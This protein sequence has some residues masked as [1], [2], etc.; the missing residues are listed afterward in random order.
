MYGIYV[1]TFIVYSDE[2]YNVL[3]YNI[4]T[5]SVFTRQE[6]GLCYMIHGTDLPSGAKIEQHLWFSHTQC[7]DWQLGI[8]WSETGYLHI[9]AKLPTA[10]ALNTLRSRYNGIW[11]H[12]HASSL[13]HFNEIWLDI[14]ANRSIKKKPTLMAWCQ[15]T[16]QYLTQCMMSSWNENIFNVTGPL[17]G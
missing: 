12:F 8:D 17:C 16:K 9:V 14:I 11:M 15:M 10:L 7:Y 5:I 2:P 3:Q 6:Y 13:L 1:Y 4:V